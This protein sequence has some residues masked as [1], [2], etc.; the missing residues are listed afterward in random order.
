MKSLVVPALLAVGL[1]ALPAQAG[2]PV[3]GSALSALIPGFNGQGSG[4][5]V[6]YGTD[7]KVTIVEGANTYRGKWRI[8]HNRVCNLINELAQGK[9]TCRR[10]VDEGDDNYRFTRV[11]NGRTYVLHRMP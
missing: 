11:D 3:E 9:E 4:F 10:V 7:G 1:W 2:E 6:S 5:T 8:S